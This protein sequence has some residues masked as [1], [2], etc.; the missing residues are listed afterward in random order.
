M[1]VLDKKVALI[2]G[3]SAP[4]GI[5]RTIALRLAQD[6][7]HIVVTDIAGKCIVDDSEYN[8]S[9]LLDKLVADIQQ[10]GVSAHAV[11]ADISS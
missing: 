5:G 1:R 2:T 9:A 10:I 8:R 7:A 4:G 6:G 11:T 3:A